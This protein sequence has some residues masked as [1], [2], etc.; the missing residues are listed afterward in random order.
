MRGRRPRG[1]EIV[2]TLKGEAQARERLEVI[3]KTLSS[4][5]FTAAARQLGVTT[6]R[7][8]QLRQLALEASLAALAPQ[9]LGRPSTSA[10]VEPE[11]IDALRRDNERLRQELAASKLR[12]EIALVLPRRPRR[13]EKKRGRGSSS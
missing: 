12:E 8:H 7:L 10:A 13:V 4:L 3:L 6:Q 11:Q 2:R 1:P 5:N 9:P